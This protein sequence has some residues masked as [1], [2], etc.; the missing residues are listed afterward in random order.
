MSIGTLNGIRDDDV[1]KDEYDLALEEGIDDETLR[2]DPGA[3]KF[4]ISSYGADYTVDSLVKR[5]RGG[6]FRIPEFQRQFVWTPK[7]ASKF[8]ESLLMGLPVPGVFLYKEADTNEHLVIDGQQRLRTLEAFYDGVLRGKEFKL[9]GVRE[10]W[11]NQTYKTLDP[12]DILK[13]DDSIVHATIFK[14]DKP[15]DVL[16]SIYFVFERINTG[17]IRLSP[18]EI[19]NCISLGPFIERV[20]QLNTFPP[21]RGV[22][23]SQNNRAKDEELIVRFFA[24]YRDGDKYTRP[25]NG[26]LNKFSAAMNKVGKDELDRLSKVFQTTISKVNTA[27]GARAFRII[28]SLNAAAFDS[29]MVGLAK[30]LDTGPAP[31][32][33]DVG[34]AYDKL[35]AD[36]EFKQACERAT[37]DEENVRKRLALATAAFAGI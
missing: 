23:A 34:A 7:H 22:F 37:A 12:A 25:M 30:R 18:Q 1:R 27:I 15:E 32:D 5:M 9:Q 3:T 2:D 26:F 13:L 16:D 29:V 28:R 10:P 24:M 4:S 35:I 31:T 33:N 11:V 19:R 21:W 20:H 36:D 14:Q 8:I 17:G 6:A